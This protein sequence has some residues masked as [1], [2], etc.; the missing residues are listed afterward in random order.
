M[1]SMVGRRNRSS[2][3]SPPAEDMPGPTDRTREGCSVHEGLERL[4]QLLPRVSRGLRRPPVVDGDAAA[5]ALG[6]RHR[7]ALA[8]VRDREGTTVGSLAAALHLSLPTVSGLV[9]DLERAGFVQRLPDPAD[10]RRTLIEVVPERS[11][12]VD[13]WLEGATA[14]IVRVLEQLD[15]QERLAFVK[16]MRYLALELSERD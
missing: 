5:P 6:P 4:V 7:S 11:Q 1:K 12:C 14:P 8:L 10:R 3:G 13:A 2:E 16:G 9:G 15:P